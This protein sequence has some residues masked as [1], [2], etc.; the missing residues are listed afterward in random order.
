MCIRDR[1]NTCYTSSNKQES[2]E[3]VSI[4]Q[5]LYSQY[6][7]ISEFKL[8]TPYS[9]ANLQQQLNENKKIELNNNQQSLNCRYN[10]I[11]SQQTLQE[12]FLVFL[13]EVIEQEKKIEDQKL[14][15]CRQQDFTLINAFEY[16]VDNRNLAQIPFKNLKYLLQNSDKIKGFQRQQR[17]FQLFL[18]KFSECNLTYRNF[19]DL[20]QPNY[21]SE[22]L[23]LN[24]KG[25][26]QEYKISNETAQQLLQLLEILADNELALDEKRNILKYK[27]LNEFVFISQLLEND[28]Q[29]FSKYFL[30]KSLPEVNQQLLP[31]NWFDLLLQRFDKQQLGKLTLKDIIDDIKYNYR[32]Y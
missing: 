15:L 28:G 20:V 31:Y 29:V 19:V 13:R 26:Y 21:K 23:I 7:P 18:K 2:P 14:I 4:S 24:N 9:Q 16:L 12:Q 5:Q 3:Q 8:N 25:Y 10:R 1:S 17:L 11:D 30:G 22:A 32:T 27:N 6:G